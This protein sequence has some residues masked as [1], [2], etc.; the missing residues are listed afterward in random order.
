M[1]PTVKVLQRRGLWTIVVRNTVL[2]PGIRWQRVSSCCG[3]SLP[4]PMLLSWCLPTCNA[5]CLWTCAALQSPCQRIDMDI[6]HAYTYCCLMFL[7]VFWKCRWQMVPLFAPKSHTRWSIWQLV[8]CCWS[9]RSNE[10][11]HGMFQQWWTHTIIAKCY[12][13]NCSLFELLL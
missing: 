2:Q 1:C 12:I 3:F 6:W 11:R 5:W 10:S 9:N 13:L 7:D 4:Y 8:A